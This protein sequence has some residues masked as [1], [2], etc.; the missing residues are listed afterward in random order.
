MQLKMTHL[1][2]RSRP[3]AK[4]LATTRRAGVAAVAM[5]ALAA[6]VAAQNLFAPALTVN[7]DVITKG[8]NILT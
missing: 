6:P 5:V 7:D 2:G 8:V 4:V 1:I 3:L